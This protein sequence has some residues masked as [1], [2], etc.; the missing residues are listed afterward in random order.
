MQLDYKVQDISRLMMFFAPVSIARNMNV[1]W[2]S[3]ILFSFGY[4]F[5]SSIYSL[6]AVFQVLQ[7][8]GILGFM[9]SIAVLI[10]V[11]NLNAYFFL[12]FLIYIFWQLFFVI[13][14]NFRN[15]E[16]E[17]VKSLFFNGNYGLISILVPL[18]S[19]LPVTLVNIK[20]LFDASVILFFL[21][22]LFTLTLLPDLLNPD[23]YNSFSREAFEL[24]VKFLA[25]PV[26]FILLTFDL[27]SV[28]RKILSIVIFSVIMIF[29]ILRARRGILLMC[30]IAAV[31]ALTFYF[32]RSSKRL[33]WA[34]AIVYLLVLVYQL[35]TIDYSFSKI[36]FLSNIHERG[37]EN[38]RIYVVDCFYSSMST[39]DWIIGKGYNVG[40]LCPGMEESV[41]NNGLR[42]IIETDYLQL[43]LTGGLINLILLMGIILPAVFLGLF[44]SSNIFCKK[45]ATW[46]LIWVFFLYPSNA[47]TVSIFHISIWLMIALCYNKKFREL[48]DQTIVNYFTKDIKI[49]TN[50]KA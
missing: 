12:I 33:G 36:Q 17:E 45:A 24:S 7:I 47:Y 48:S 25:F 13:R 27:H 20:K 35:Y 14:G 44:H 29:A 23:P 1:F 21:Y 31:F 28:K 18:V 26:C 39:M 11:E 30:S 50:G 6:A 8:I 46:I 49:R 22:L 3:I 43:I 2:I 16:Y 15:L 38:T 41:Y 5:S 32:F 37:L 34:L 9:F 19:L 40:Y 42:K 4:V 10:K